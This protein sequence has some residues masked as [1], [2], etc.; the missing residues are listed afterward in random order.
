MLTDTWRNQNA[1]KS[2]GDTRYQLHMSQWSSG[3]IDD[4]SMTDNE[5]SSSVE[6]LQADVMATVSEAND[7]ERI[8]MT[9]ADVVDSAKPIGTCGRKGGVAGDDAVF[10]GVKKSECDC[11]EAA[12]GGGTHNAWSFCSAPSCGN[13]RNHC[14]MKVISWEIHMSFDQFHLR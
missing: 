7:P 5:D 4:F 1:S 3:I 11:Y 14:W 13:Q 8:S 6:Q 2:G 10:L 12:A 9:S